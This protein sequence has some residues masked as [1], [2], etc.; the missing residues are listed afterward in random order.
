MGNPFVIFGFMVWLAVTIAAWVIGI[1]AM[2][3]GAEDGDGVT[4]GIGTG[5][6]LGGMLS[7]S[8]FLATLE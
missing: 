2:A 3:T 1:G 5:F 8:F 4:F 7:T 6:L